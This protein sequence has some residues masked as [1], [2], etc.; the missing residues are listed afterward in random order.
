MKFSHAL[1]IIVLSLSS[2]SF[3][4]QDGT[5]PPQGPEGRGR[6]AGQPQDGERPARPAIDPAQF[7]DRLMQND[8]NGDGQLSKDELP[9]A[10]S[11]RLMERADTN[12][13][14][15]LDK[16]ELEAAA[17][18]GAMGAGRGAAREGGRGAAEGG[19][20]VEGA[21]K[22]MNR[23]YKALGESSFDA[24]SRASD[25]G[26][27]QMLQ[28]SAVAAKGGAARMPMSDA[29]KQ[30]FGED[31]EKFDAAFRTMMLETLLVSIELEKAVLVGD[32]AS[33]KSAVAKLHEMEEKG[34]Q[35]FQPAEGEARPERGARGEGAPPATEG[36]PARGGR[37]GR[38]QQGG[39]LQP[40]RPQTER[41]Q[42]G[43]PS[44]S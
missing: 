37:G 34:H 39:G 10:L 27:V 19:M 18:S 12:K 17:K 32:S 2:A 42:R 15:M 13:D 31:R 26:M 4:Q 44:G 23:A 11:E 22:Q 1:S 16:G 3:A 38:G 24:A 36:Q 25:L 9:P 5:F 8:A 20:N 33:A 40:G 41:P 29:A 28:S 7:V 21:M 6:G 35:L 14:G 30:Q 43:A